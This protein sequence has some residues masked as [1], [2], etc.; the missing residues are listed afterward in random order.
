MSLTV[1]AIAAIP[2][3]AVVV[4]AVRT[5]SITATTLAAIAAGSI[6]IFTGSPHYALLDIFA[7]A[8]AT[9]LAWP[10]AKT[11]SPIKS[12]P[13]EAIPPPAQQQ[14]TPQVPNGSVNQPQ[15][16]WRSD[17]PERYCGH[18]RTL[19]TYPKIGIFKKPRCTNCGHPL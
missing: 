14:P 19:S 7:V 18:C 3:I 2:A 8:V 5:N 13:V 6:G 15:V 10:D 16:K 1:L 4:V 9:W 17:H 12:S 11:Q